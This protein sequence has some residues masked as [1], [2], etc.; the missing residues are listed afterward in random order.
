[1]II[2][3]DLI[4][5]VGFYYTIALITSVIKAIKICKYDYY[6]APN[7]HMIAWGM[8]FFLL[9]DIN[10]GLANVQKVISISPGLLKRFL[11]SSY[12]LIWLFYLPSQV[13]LTLSGY[14][15]S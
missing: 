9:C 15:Y 13:L 6:P 10:V 14:K 2:T 11:D 5:V 4:Y 7:K 3:I 1:F 12:L 8:I